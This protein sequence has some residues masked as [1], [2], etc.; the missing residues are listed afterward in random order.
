MMDPPDEGDKEP[1]KRQE[2]E[3]R[4][5]E[6][7]EIKRASS[8]K[9]IDGIDGDQYSG[10]VQINGIFKPCNIHI[11]E[12]NQNHQDGETIVSVITG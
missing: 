10:I 12:A 1:G 9:I 4:E 5:G 2:D 11:R 3:N 6:N 8:T 7:H